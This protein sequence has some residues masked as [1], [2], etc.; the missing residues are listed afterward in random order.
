MRTITDIS[1]V[2]AMAPGTNYSV[3]LPPHLL[4]CAIGAKIGDCAAVPQSKDEDKAA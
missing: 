2:A 1:I 4:R 3:L